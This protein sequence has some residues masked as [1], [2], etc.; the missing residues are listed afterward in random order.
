MRKVLASIAVASAAA[1]VAVVSAGPASADGY[2][3]PGRVC[4]WEDRDFSGSRY[5][6]VAAVP[7][8][9]NIDGWDG[10]NEITS[11]DNAS[12]REV[13]VYDN[14]NCTGYLFTQYPH[15]RTPVL[16]PSLNDRAECFRIV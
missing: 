11:L 14:D 10:D 9:Y 6:D 13:W 1:G 12:G 16:S 3:P 4:M 7:G 15:T 8:T 2:C 5:V